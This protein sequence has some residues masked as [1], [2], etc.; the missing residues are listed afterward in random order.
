[1]S[2]GPADEL[3]VA[4]FKRLEKRPT[5]FHVFDDNT[6]VVADVKPMEDFL[7][8][9]HGDRKRQPRYLTDPPKPPPPP[10]PPPAP[11]DAA[12][13]PAE[14]AAE[15]SPPQ[16]APAPPV[17]EPFLTVKPPL[18]RVLDALEFKRRTLTFVAELGSALAAGIHLPGGVTAGPNE[19]RAYRTLFG[20]EPPLASGLA[21]QTFT[22]GRLSMTA[23]A[24]MSSVGE[25]TTLTAAARTAVVP[26]LK[27]IEEDRRLKI[28]LKGE[29]PPAPE[30][31]PDRTDNEDGAPPGEGESGQTPEGQTPGTTNDSMQETVDLMESTLDVVG[32]GKLV[33]ATLDLRLSDH[34]ALVGQMKDYLV[35]QVTAA[36][37]AAMIPYHASHRERLADALKRYVEKHGAFPR[38][39]AQ[40]PADRGQPLPWR[41]D[42]RLAWTAELLPHF[43]TPYSALATDPKLSWDEGVNAATAGM[44]VPHLMAPDAPANSYPA[45]TWRN[46]M[47]GGTAGVGATHFVGVAGVGVDAAEYDP[48]DE[49]VKTKR[50]VFTYD[51]STK[52]ADITDTPGAT[53]ALL[54]V[55]PAYKTCWLAGGGSTVREVPETDPLSP[56]VCAEYKGKKGTFAIMADFKVRFIPAD[57][58]P[59]T[60]KG[61]CTIAGGEKIADLDKVAPPVEPEP[62]PAAPDATKPPAEK[63]E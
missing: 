39:T 42:Q 51:H 32:N 19:V 47:P 22:H 60:F 28:R 52:P 8:A 61:L 36:R 56:F 24:E 1:V 34:T 58:D 30:P 54:Q 33:L 41:P 4:L 20:L 45:P 14:A 46:P 18:K 25:A 5:A 43:G 9:S 15:Q 63:K 16:P 37:N 29:P 21:L 57:T 26:L 35:E 27:K 7:A 17:T 11:K 53:I 13:P 12:P 3:T 44:V 48:T 31:D 50:G 49:T 62:A 6:L 2:D 55:P 59:E 10:A 38:G 40:R 23:A